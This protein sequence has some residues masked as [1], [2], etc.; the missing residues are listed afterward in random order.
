MNTLNEEALRPLCLERRPVRQTQVLTPMAQ[1]ILSAMER[2]NQAFKEG[3]PIEEIQV[4]LPQ[5]SKQDLCVALATAS[6]EY[7]KRYPGS[8]QRW[9][10]SRRKGRDLAFSKGVTAILGLSGRTTRRLIKTGRDILKGKIK[11]KGL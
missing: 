3:S 7:S 1:A 9:S 10:K 6:K 2:A 8:L 5:G 4:S 11:I